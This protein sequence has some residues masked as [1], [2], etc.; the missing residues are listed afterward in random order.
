MIGGAH[1]RGIAVKLVR[2]RASQQHIGAAV[3]DQHIRP[4]AA[5]EI[6]IP[7]GRAAQPTGVA[8]QGIGAIT[9]IQMIPPSI[10]DQQ[11]VTGTAIELC[12]VAGQRAA[13]ADTGLRATG[14]DAHDVLRLVRT[15]A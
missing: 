8:I 11:I 5:V 14:P 3:A 7:V 4:G 1:A 6:V 10:T 13:A 15:F 12:T 2:V 9:A